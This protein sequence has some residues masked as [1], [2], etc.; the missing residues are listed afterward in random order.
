M[1]AAFDA[2][3]RIEQLQQTRGGC[4]DPSKA[5]SLESL[6]QEGMSGIHGDIAW[7][8]RYQIVMV[9]KLLGDFWQHEAYRDPGLYDWGGLVAAAERIADARSPHS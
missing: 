1:R 5:S 3:V 9:R 7:L 4:R 2:V 6:V 8:E